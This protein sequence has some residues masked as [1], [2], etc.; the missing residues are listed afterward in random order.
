MADARAEY[1]RRLERWGEAIAQGERAHLLVSNF[2]L[3]AALAA[4]VLAWLAF[5]RAML[6][7]GWVL[8]PA[9]TFA[10]LVV[11]HARLLNRNERAIRARQFYVDGLARMDD[12][13]QEIGS[14]G[15]RFLA[16]EH[17]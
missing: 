15:N 6:S 2:R 3:V 11:V 4:G 8:L 17:P 12:Q 7:P 9:G 13:W 10:V 16:D 1:S 14:D 5:G